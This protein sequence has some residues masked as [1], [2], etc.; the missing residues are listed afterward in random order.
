METAPTTSDAENASATASATAGAPSLQAG[1][2]VTTAYG[3]GTVLRI[4]QEDERA[5]ARC[6]ISLIE[7]TMAQVKRASDVFQTLANNFFLSTL[8]C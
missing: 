6:A 1:D 4:V 2:A 7:W 5:A 3:K 8:Y